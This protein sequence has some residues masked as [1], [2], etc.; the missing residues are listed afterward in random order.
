VEASKFIEQ[1]E[2]KILGMEDDQEKI[3]KYLEENW[4]GV[5]IL[6]TIKAEANVVNE[7]LKSMKNKCFVH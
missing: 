5:L 7:V 3:E 6:E 2:H 1:L 4:I